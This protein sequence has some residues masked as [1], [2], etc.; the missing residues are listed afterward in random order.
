MCTNCL[1]SW[2]NCFAHKLETQEGHF[3][4]PHEPLN[5]SRWSKGFK[6]D[7]PT[8]SLGLNMIILSVIVRVL[9]GLVSHATVV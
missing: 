9:R 5:E 1:L 6:V 4:Y 8:M 2:Y 7:N 3:Q